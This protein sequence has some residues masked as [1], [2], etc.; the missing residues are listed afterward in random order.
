MPC[1]GPLWEDGPMV[2][3]IIARISMNWNWLMSDGI[4]GKRCPWLPL[5]DAGENPWLSGQSHLS[6][7][8]LSSWGAR[9]ISTPSPVHRHV[10]SLVPPRGPRPWTLWWPVIPWSPVTVAVSWRPRL[11]SRSENLAWPRRTVRPRSRFGPAWTVSH[12]PFT[13][14]RRPVGPWSHPRLGIPI[15][16]R[17]PRTSFCH[18]RPIGFRRH[19]PGWTV[20]PVTRLRP[21]WTIGLGRT[22]EARWTVAL[23]LHNNWLDSCRRWLPRSPRNVAE[24]IT[25]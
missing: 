13:R 1:C 22:M 21:G 12:C 2:K 25:M 18:V 16:P 6:A 15:R 5:D 3:L 7:D 14:T 24:L 11:M 19:G 4:D 10:F 23:Q 8:D 17:G 9:L 20:S